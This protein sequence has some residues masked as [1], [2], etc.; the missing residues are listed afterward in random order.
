MTLPSHKRQVRIIPAHGPGPHQ[1]LDVV[2][3]QRH[4]AIAQVGPV[5]GVNAACARGK[6][7]ERVVVGVLVGKEKVKLSRAQLPG[8]S[9]P[10]L[11]Q[12]LGQLGV[13]QLEKLD[14]VAGAR[15]QRLPELEL[16]AESACLA[17]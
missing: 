14:V 16:L 12:L 2:V 5:L 10:L 11:N 7:D 6:R 8:N 9:R 17:T 1:V 15:L 4:V 3:V 13:A